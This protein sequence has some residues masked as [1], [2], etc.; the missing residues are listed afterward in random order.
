MVFFKLC[1]CE[2]VF[3]SAGRA[4]YGAYHGQKQRHIMETVYNGPGW[5]GAFYLRDYHKR[6][7]LRDL[8]MLTF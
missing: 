7:K 2:R 4:K 6:V 5:T 3:K 1:C 8:Y